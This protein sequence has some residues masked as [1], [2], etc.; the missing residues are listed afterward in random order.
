[1]SEDTPVRKVK[2]DISDWSV[3]GWDLALR[4]E[5]FEVDT[6]WSF[7]EL[8]ITVKK[9]ALFDNVVKRIVKEGLEAF[10]DD[11]VICVVEKEGL[12]LKPQEDKTDEG[13][14]IPWDPWWLD[15][16]SSELA[17]EILKVIVGQYRHWELPFPQHI[18]DAALT[19]D[20]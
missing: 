1:M 16:K 10:F 15:L 7:G 14:L 11:G 6:E 8:T 20:E 9:S 4:D 19:E 12:R 2:L 3:D 13:F 18:V 17:E 5:A